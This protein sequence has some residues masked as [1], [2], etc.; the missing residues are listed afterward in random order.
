MPLTL[1]ADVFTQKKK[2]KKKSTHKT[3]TM[4]APH[5][6]EKWRA[7]VAEMRAAI[8][9]LSLPARPHSTNGLACSA[10]NF[11]VA[12][13]G[14]EI[15]HF[16]SEPELDHAD[17][18]FD[19][20]ED[21]CD[22]IS[23]DNASKYGAEW[24]AEKCVSIASRRD[25]LSPDAL[26]C[27]VA[28]TLSSGRSEDEIQ[29]VL[30]DLIGFDDLDFVTHL[31]SHRQ[32]ITGSLSKPAVVEVDGRRLLTKAER[33]EALWR[34]DYQHKNTPLLPNLSR[35]EQYPHVYRSFA[36]NNTLSHSG[37]RY[38]LPVGSERLQLDKYEEYVI[39]AG[40]KGTLLPAQKQVQISELDGL[41]RGTFKGYKS[42]NRMQSL[43]F[44]VAYKTSE[45]MLICAPTGAVSVN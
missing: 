26:R 27:Q 36:A 19:D 9:S 22:D 39:P 24:L 41:C 42:L 7:Q 45:N 32:A 40:R 3:S 29:S 44:P 25:G 13:S 6:L 35:E 43:V 18:D 15:W 4:T 1:L 2:K 34:R 38:A 28:E 21:L 33:H 16:V 17:D 37:R 5:T 8:A 31:L 30:I 20:S 10:A 11:I 14:K 23:G 12:A